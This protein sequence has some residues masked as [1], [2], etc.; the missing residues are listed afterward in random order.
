[1]H[2][3]QEGSYH[4]SNDKNYIENE[5]RWTLRIEGSVESQ[6][7]KKFSSYLKKIIIQL[8]EEEYKDDSFIEWNINSLPPSD[9]FE[10]TR[11]GYK[12]T[13]VKILLVKKKNL[14]SFF[15]FKRS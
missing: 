9:G 13:T 12:D 6:N 10:V 7:K 15:S 1:M 8:D 2:S 4:I 3:N 14:K 5:P 11:K